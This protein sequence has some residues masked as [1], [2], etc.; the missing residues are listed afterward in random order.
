MRKRVAAELGGA[1]RAECPQCGATW[2]AGVDR[3]SNAG[4]LLAAVCHAGVAG[5]KGLV[6]RTV[7]VTASRTRPEGIFDRFPVISGRSL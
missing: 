7:T 3:R 5:A 2:I 4:L 1:G 6:R